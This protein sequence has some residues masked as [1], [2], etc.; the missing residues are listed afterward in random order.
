MLAPTIVFRP[1][2][3]AHLA[4]HGVDLD[5]VARRQNQS[6]DTKLKASDFTINEEGVPQTIRS[7]RLVGGREARV[8]TA[9]PE[10]V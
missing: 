1:N 2:A 6:L 3:S 9:P 10:A 7:F 4:S 8:I 5:V